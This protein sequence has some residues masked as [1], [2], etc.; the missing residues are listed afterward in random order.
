V[1]G[2]ADTA[3]GCVRKFD[4]GHFN[5][6]CYTDGIRCDLSDCNINPTSAPNAD[7]RTNSHREA[8]TVSS[9]C[10]SVGARPHLAAE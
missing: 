9:C 1:G 4:I 2:D 3:V 10:Q 7:C 6:R 5:S 8:S